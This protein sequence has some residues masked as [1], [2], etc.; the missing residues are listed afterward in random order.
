MELALS[1]AAR[2]R[3]GEYIWN[4]TRRVRVRRPVPRGLSLSDAQRPD[5]CRAMCQRVINNLIMKRLM[6]HDSGR[7]QQYSRIHPSVKG[8]GTEVARSEP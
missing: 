6:N 3:A 2:R 8:H 7:T 4:G 1:P 5:V